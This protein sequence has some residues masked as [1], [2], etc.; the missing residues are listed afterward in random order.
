MY[1][2]PSGTIGQVT[3]GPGIIYLGATGS[4]PSMDVGYIRGKATM[5]YKREQK[6]IRQGSPQ[7]L[8][9][10]LVSQEDF[11]IEFQGIEWN[12]NNLLLV[13]GDG[14]T[15]VSGA[16]D[17]FKVG[18][19][20]AMATKALRFVHKMADGGTLEVDV[21]KALGEGTIEVDVNEND[22]HEVKYKF[23][24]VDAGS[25][26]WAGAALSDGQKLVKIVRTRP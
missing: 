24:A 1:N 6:E 12:L 22:L 13:L 15:S 10:S 14:A 11:T 16:N 4:T 7:N 2:N 26:D 21:W 8:V 18:G 5:N 9:A 20:P 23:K 25:T 19:T 3:I 17:I